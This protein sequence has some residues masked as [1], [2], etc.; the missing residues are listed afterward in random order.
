MG[1]RSIA[2]QEGSVPKPACEH[3]RWRNAR[4]SAL[5][6]GTTLSGPC[7]A[8]L[9]Q[10]GYKPC[11]AGLVAGPDACAVVAVE[12]FVK[13]DQVTPV[14]ISLEYFCSTI[15]GPAPVCFPQKDSAQALRDHTGCFPKR[16]HIAGGRRAFHLQTVA[17]IVV[18]L[19]QGFDNQEVDGKPHRPAP[20]AV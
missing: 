9:E 5:G 12:I 6:C 3:F 4:A 13:Q 14:G 18:I 8:L 1:F 19:L 10:L 11:P 2:R 20:V 15:N 17:V 7:A 16:Q